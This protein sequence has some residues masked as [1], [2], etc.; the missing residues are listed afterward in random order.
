MLPL[1]AGF[2]MAYGAN[3][4]GTLSVSSLGLT[5]MV[6]LAALAAWAPLGFSIATVFLFAAPHNWIEARY[7]VSRM[8]CR[9]QAAP[10]YFLVAIGGT[11]VLGAVFT[12]LPALARAYEWS[13]P[14]FTNTWAAWSSAMIGWVAL[15]IWLRGRQK[16]RRDWGWTAPVAFALAA[17]AW[18]AP[19]LWGFALVYLHPLM[20]FWILDRELRRRAPQWRPIFHRGLACLPTILVLMWL[21]LTQAPSLDHAN[22][23]LLTLRI[24]QHAGGTV[25]LAVSSHLLVATHAYL[26]VLHYAVWLILIPGFASRISLRNLNDIPLARRFTFARRAIGIVLSVGM[27]AVLFF[28]VAFSV[29]YAVARDLYFSLAIFHVL[30]EIPFLLRLV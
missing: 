30:A 3:G 21:V 12:A 14:T 1:R 24:V 23:N 11:L 19:D 26:E 9:W 27:L 20:A 7:F 16:P 2:T 4:S 6:V 15:L 8:P 10:G 17:F 28:W 13:V 5:A 22:E 29:D 18:F 25:L